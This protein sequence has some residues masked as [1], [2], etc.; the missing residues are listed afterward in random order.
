MSD[1]EQYFIDQWQ[2]N[3]PSVPLEGD[4][5]RSRC[6]RAIRDGLRRLD[7]LPRE[8]SFWYPSNKAPTIFKL[9]EFSTLLL[10]TDAEDVDAL[11]LRVA[12]DLWHG[13]NDAGLSSLKRIHD[14]KPE[15]FE[16]EWPIESAYILYSESGINT[17]EACS[18]MLFQLG[19]RQSASE[20]L[21]KTLEG[22]EHPSHHLRELLLGSQHQ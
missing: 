20:Y 16:V 8:D 15:E 1:V 4:S 3:W 13:C 18:T 11:W 17:L 2:K 19:L 6:L 14:V 5:L 9:S 22:E 21:H 10:S 12:L 7:A